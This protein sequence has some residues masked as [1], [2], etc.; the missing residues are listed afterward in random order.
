MAEKELEKIEI[1]GFVTRIIETDCF[2][3]ETDH[4]EAV[5]EFDGILNINA[6]DEINGLRL[7]TLSD[8]H[9]VG[10]KIF[11]F[12]EKILLVYIEPIK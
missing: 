8:I 1:D 6:G 5:A 4:C 10:K 9:L 12:E 11:N 7:A 3:E 2:D